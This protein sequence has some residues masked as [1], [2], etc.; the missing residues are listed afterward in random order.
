MSITED[1]IPTEKEKLLTAT[2]LYIKDNVLSS[3]VYEFMTT[4]IDEK[5]WSVPASSTGKYHPPFASGDGGLARHTL[6]AVLIAED[7]L[8]I[9]VLKT[10]E[11]RDAVRAA[12][13]MHDSCKQGVKFGGHTVWEHPILAGDMWTEFASSWNTD[14]A[15][16]L[17]PETVEMIA[18]CIRSHMG[19]WNTSK[20]SK[21]VLPTP[22][23]LPQKYVHICD[24]LASRRR[25]D[26]DL[27]V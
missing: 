19:K 1:N 9:S 13:I 15:C 2:K 16:T 12:L 8:E 20:Y 17:S 26:V 6:A 5:F 23:T 11:E 27:N 25:I 21:I 10:N 7:L 4:A 24:Y 3:A 22:K 14:G 18:G